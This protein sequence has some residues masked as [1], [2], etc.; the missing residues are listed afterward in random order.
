MRTLKINADQ[1]STLEGFYQ[2]LTPF[3]DEGKCPWGEN[4]DSLEEVTQARFN[5]TDDPSKNVSRI[6]WN[7]FSKSERELSERRGSTTA[8]EIIKQIFSGHPKIDFLKEE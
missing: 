7:G 5:Y 6:I 8:I 1:F 4:L 2:S 3:L